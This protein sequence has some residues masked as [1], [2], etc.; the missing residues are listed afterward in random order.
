M[1]YQGKI[2]DMSCVKEINDKLVDEYIPKHKRALSDNFND[3]QDKMDGIYEKYIQKF[4]NKFSGENG[5]QE[6]EKVG[7]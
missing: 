6:S 7:N 3:D 4:S 2:G 5:Q 1:K